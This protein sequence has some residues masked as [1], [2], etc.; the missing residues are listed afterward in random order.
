VLPAIV[1]TAGL[2]TRLD[3]ITRLVAKA[4]VPLAGQTLVE[5]SLHRLAA[6]GVTEAVLNLHHLPETITGVVGDGSQLGMRVRYS[7]EP[8]ILGSAGGPRRA[9]SLLDAPRVLIINGDTL[10]DVDL[11]EMI[12]QHER[13]RA[14]VTMSVVPN[15]APD[16][17]N[18]IRLDDE[19]RVTAFVPKGQA[20]G[21]WHFIGVQ[22]A[23]ARVFAPLAD[24]VPAETV[25]GIYREMVASSPGAVCGFPIADP[26]V[27]VGTARD[28]LAAAL[29]LAG[30]HTN[31]AI[32]PG[33][34]ISPTAALAG[35][36]VWPGASIGTGAVLERCIVTNVMVPAGF[37]ATNAV[38]M[39]ASDGV[40]A[41]PI[42]Q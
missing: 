4:A 38:L 18:G 42:N 31:N 35:C 24:G 12:L 20:A 22:I 39:P 36:V 6:Q 15:P 11:A 25:A 2:G 33:A 21:T 26:F 14:L 8:T 41:F 13:T 32:E 30:A 3:P 1:L 40:S 34:T 9:L 23:E 10:C 19:N 28:Y 7:W 29:T 17:Y 37:R 27:D 5:R 16:H